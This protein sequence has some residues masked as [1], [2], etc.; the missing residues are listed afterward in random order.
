LKGKIEQLESETEILK[1]FSSA[2]RTD[3]EKSLLKNDS[4]AKNIDFPKLNGEKAFEVIGIPL[5]KPGFYIV[6]V[7][8]LILVK[9]LLGKPEPMYVSSAALVTNLS[10][11][12]KWGRENS[13]VWVTTLNTGDPVKNVP[14][15]IRDCRGKALWEER[16]GSDGTVLIKP[17]SPGQMTHRA[18]MG[19]EVVCICKDRR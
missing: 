5:K 4:R 10:V 19:P 15:N 17:L 14:V 6:E 11:H 8:S 16:T 7:E 9:S 18:A 2:Q 1:R 13:L 3:R 12:F